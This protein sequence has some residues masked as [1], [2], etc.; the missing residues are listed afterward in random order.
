MLLFLTGLFF[1][2]FY[3]L[4][5]NNNSNVDGLIELKYDDLY[6]YQKDKQAYVVFITKFESPFDN[7]E[8]LFKEKIIKMIKENEEFKF[9]KTEYPN[10]IKK[11][12]K[13][14]EQI[15]KEITLNEYQPKE[16]FDLI[17]KTF[18]SDFLISLT[19]N[20]KNNQLYVCWNHAIIDGLRIC[21]ISLGYYNSFVPYKL[22]LPINT[23]FKTLL[24]L[25]KH[26]I[27]SNP[28]NKKV[29]GLIQSEKSTVYNFILDNSE[30]DL[31]K[32]KEKCSFMGAFQSLILSKLKG[33]LDKILVVTAVGV[34]KSFQFNKVGGIAYHIELSNYKDNIGKIVDQKLQENKHHYM[35]STNKYL[36]MFTKKRKQIDLLFSSVPIS[37]KNLYFGNQEIKNY[38]T[39]MPFHSST[40]YIFSCKVE[41]KIYVTIGI[42]NDKIN[43]YVKKYNWNLIN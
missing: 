31:I 35:L 14:F 5:Y 11:T 18:Q 24:C 26:L 9:E 28:F 7:M 8:D 13:P 15:Y 33:C 1:I 37:K 2:G 22:N 12:T 34:K 40:V 38:I 30:I 27:S 41:N 4:Y 20:T 17:E 3:Y 39:F 25:G 16:N 23:N 6:H 43:N 10:K 32:E 42:K 21:E 29:D 36:K 19:M